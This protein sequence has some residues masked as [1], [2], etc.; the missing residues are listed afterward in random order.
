MH[1]LER[2]NCKVHILNNIVHAVAKEPRVENLIRKTASLVKYMKKGGFNHTEGIAL[3][4]YCPTRFNTVCTM[5]KSVEAAYDAMYRILEKRKSSGNPN[6]RNCMERIEC[7]RKSTLRE[8]IEFLEPFKCWID[9]LERDKTVTITDVW[10]TQIQL[11]EHI[12]ENEFNLDSDDD[13]GIFA[14]MKRIAR[15]YMKKNE[16]D[17]RITNNQRIAMVLNPQ[18]K[19]LKRVA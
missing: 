4:S 5:F 14:S 11:E 18:M 8:V 3:Q 1:D 17:F 2:S 6:H 9:R 12:A 15:E 7:I 10:V 13:V 16:F 19:K